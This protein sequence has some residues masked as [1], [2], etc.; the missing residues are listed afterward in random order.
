MGSA[1][2]VSL[3]GVPFCLM[4]LCLFPQVRVSSTKPCLDSNSHVST[5][6]GFHLLRIFTRR[7]PAPAFAKTRRM[8]RIS[9][10]PFVEL[11]IQAASQE[12]WA[13][14]QPCLFLFGTV[15]RA[16]ANLSFQNPAQSRGPLPEKRETRA[17]GARE[18][19]AFLGCWEYGVP[20]L[21]EKEETLSPGNQQAHH[22]ER[23]DCVGIDQSFG[24]PRNKPLPR[25]L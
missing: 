8:V 18:V 24:T 22:R 6:H 4:H 15:Q 20:N 19:K 13:S 9:P 10:W 1:S 12:S 3:Y 23:G 17:L 21:F 11:S 2:I 5:C 7:A 16:T 14:G 25:D